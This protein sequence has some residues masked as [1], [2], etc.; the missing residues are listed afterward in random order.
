MVFL[1][2]HRNEIFEGAVNDV[3][4]NDGRGRLGVSSDGS[5]H[6]SGARCRFWRPGAASARRGV[7]WCNAAP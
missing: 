3:N 5:A 7:V 4:R 1:T 2:V 6:A